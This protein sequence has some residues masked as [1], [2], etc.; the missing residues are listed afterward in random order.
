MNI[1]FFSCWY[2][3]RNDEKNGIFVKE[4][5]RSI[6]GS[7]ENIVVFAVL[8]QKN[9]TLFNKETEVFT[10]EN[11]VETHILYLRSKFYKWIYINIP[12]MFSHAFRYYRK[13]I[14]PK[15]KPDI[16]HSNILYPAGIMGYKMSQKIKK[17][18]IITEHW[19]KLDKFFSKSV[20]KYIGKRAYDSAKCIT[21]VSE[22]LI[23]DIKKHTANKNIVRIPNVINEAFSYQPKSKNLSQLRFSAVATWRYPKLPFVL[24]DAL[25]SVQKNISKE[26]IFSVV[27][28]GPLFEEMKEKA[29]SLHYKIIFH[30]NLQRKDI[31]DI[32]HQSDFFVH[33]SA[34]ETFSVVIT[35]ALAAGTPVIASNTG[36]IPELINETNGMLCE[37]TADD[38]CKKI[39]EALNTE[40]RHDEIG[41]SALSQYSSK[42]IGKF[43]KNIY[44]GI[45]N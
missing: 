43:F 19:S 9:N 24:I 39:L 3:G 8:V 15:F 5:A 36:A 20:Y 11:G 10:D 42:E 38:F 26:I 4:H 17:P 23:S 35:E 28:E 29:K 14:S 27:G 44:L 22:F 33:A 37:N 32:L 1:L 12:L 25:E 13:I 18:H 6:K 2:P 31:A 16:I 7:G 30:G 45:G 21:A 40:Y 41:K 34:V